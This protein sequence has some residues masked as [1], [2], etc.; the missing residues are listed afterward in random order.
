MTLVG[1]DIG[2][3]R[4]GAT[5]VGDVFDDAATGQ[6]LLNFFLCGI[7]CGA[8]TEDEARVTG[9]T[10]DELHRRPVPDGVRFVTI[11]GSGDLVV[12]G[13]VA[14]DDVADHAIILPTDVGTEVHGTLPSNPA[15]TRE[16]GLAVAGLGPTCQGAGAALSAFVEAETIRF[17]ETA[18]A[19]A[20]A[21]AAGVLPLP[22]A[23]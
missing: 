15:A 19:A 3:G 8:I 17:G 12:P 14:I 23:D 2:S 7:N 1:R 18:S 11:G 5:L 4:G 20:L 6:G 10:I 22:P 9:L 16:I 13:S 21:V